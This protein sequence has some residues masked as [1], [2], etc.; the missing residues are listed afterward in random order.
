MTILVS[1]ATGAVGGRLVDRLV[2]AGEMPRIASRHPSE[3][4][5]RWPGFDAVELDVLRPLT[6]GPAL[7]GVSSAYY[8]VHSME[9]EADGDFK[10]RDA[11]GAAAFGEAAID[12]GVKRVIYLGG[13]GEESDGLSEHL[14]S[15]HETG[16]IL[17][18]TGP[19]LLE[20]RASMVMSAESASFIMLSDLVNRLPA[21]IVPRWVDTPSQPIAVDDVLSYLVAGLDTPLPDGRTIVEIGGPDVAD[22]PPDDRG[23]LRRARARPVHRRGAAALARPLLVLGRARHVGAGVT[24]SSV[25]RGHD[26]ADDRSSR[27]R[28]A[29]VP[30]HRAHAVHRRD[31]AR[32]RRSLSGRS[33]IRIEAH[34]DASRREIWARYADPSRWPEWAPQIAT[35]RADGPLRE[36]LVGEVVG[37]FGT[38]ATFVVTD[39]DEDAGRWSWRVRGGVGRMRAALWIEHHVGEG[40]AALD[41]SGFAPVALAYEPFARLALARLVRP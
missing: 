29:A 12:A 19:P 20:F 6:L 23:H 41:V 13:L 17:A 27:R 14:E 28:V 25:D 11:E 1:G 30:R 4:L 24:R 21:M 10:R 9:A 8:L 34:G 18:E 37:R 40:W 22:L 2:A 16:R 32:L 7:D 26:R 35:V 33:S 5:D 3:L 39:V 36:G 38:T 31:Q 15:R